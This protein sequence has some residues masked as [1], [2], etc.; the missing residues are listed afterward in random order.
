MYD[1]KFERKKNEYVEF[2]Y[3]ASAAVIGLYVIS[4][5]DRFR[6]FYLAVSLLGFVFCQLGSILLTGEI[7]WYYCVFQ[8][9]K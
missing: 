2:Y 4:V 9:K 3:H 1:K 5:I 7:K 6:V 8:E